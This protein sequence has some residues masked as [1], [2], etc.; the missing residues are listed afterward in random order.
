VLISAPLGL[1]ARNL[2]AAILRLILER[3][4]CSK[5]PER[6]KIVPENQILEQ[7]SEFY[8]LEHVI[9]YITEHFRGLIAR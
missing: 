3:E 8:Y 9:S 4:S 7:A 1:A 6:W 5:T 2:K